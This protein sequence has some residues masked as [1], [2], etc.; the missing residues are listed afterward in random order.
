MIVK[1]DQK[2]QAQR[3]ARWRK[4]ARSASEQSQRSDLPE[5]EPVQEIRKVLAHC[6]D[7]DLKIIPH[8]E[9][10]RRSL[11][12]V[13]SAKPGKNILILIGPEGDF[14]AAEVAAAKKA[15]CILVDLGERVLRVDTAAIAVA[16]FIRLNENG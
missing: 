6:G 14:T 9:G 1:F 12:E 10:E 15:G 13:I 11:K 2:K 5:I 4:I 16:S 7:Y 8:L 3:L